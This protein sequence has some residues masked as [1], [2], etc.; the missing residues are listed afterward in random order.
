MSAMRVGSV[1]DSASASRS[2]RSTSDA[3]TVSS[4]D[5]SLPGTSWETPP[6]FQP[7]G[8]EISPV[9]KT[10]SPRMMRNSVVLPV[11]LRPTR[12]TLWPVGIV[13]VVFSI[14]VRPCTEYVISEMRNIRGH[15]HGAARWSI[16]CFQG[17]GVMLARGQFNQPKRGTSH[18]YPAHI[19]DHQ[20]RRHKA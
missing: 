1:A 3:S 17:R 15:C 20:T 12:P 2:T 14:R 19:F 13:T 4:S 5:T 6:I 7:L 9:S 18:G 8:M 10:I 16:R 11:P